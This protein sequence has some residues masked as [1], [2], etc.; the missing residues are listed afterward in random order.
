MPIS[1]TAVSKTDSI[2]S[3]M[4]LDL[5]AQSHNQMLSY[6]LHCTSH[7]IHSLSLRQQSQNSLTNTNN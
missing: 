6:W 7:S 1:A 4:T 3:S 2:K 5:R